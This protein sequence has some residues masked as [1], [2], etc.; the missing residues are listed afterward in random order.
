MPHAWGTTG[1]CYRS[2]LVSGTPDSWF[3]LLRPA[4]ELKGKVTMLASDRWLMGAGLFALGYS[5]N[6]T[7]PEQIG[8]ARDLLIEA[9]QSLLAYDDTTFYAKL[10][11]GEAAL[12][13]AWDGWCNYGIAE[14]PDIKFVVPKEGS[15]AWV[16]TM[17]VVEAS[18]NKEDAHAFINFVLRPEIHAWAVENILYKVPNQAAMES[19]DTSL[20]ETYPN[21]AMRPTDLLKLEGLRDL[22]EAQRYYTRAVTEITASR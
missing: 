14:N 21:L 9:K 3:D 4:D 19:V 16:D 22:G 8:E 11:T 5:I 6:A 17:V 12:V 7:D 10:V 20:F 15:D 2:D 18:P 1:L 13:H